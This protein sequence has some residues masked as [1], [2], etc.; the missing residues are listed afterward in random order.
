MREKGRPKGGLL[1]VTYGRLG[2][3]VSLDSDT[4]SPKREVRLGVGVEPDL[5][6]T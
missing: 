5:E 1:K 3:R 2:L 6:F 4:P